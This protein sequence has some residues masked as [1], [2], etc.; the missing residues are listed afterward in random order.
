M[1]RTLTLAM[2]V[3]LGSLL[4]VDGIAVSGEM[5]AVWDQDPNKQPNLEELK[6]QLEDPNFGTRCRAVGRL[7]SMRAHAEEVAPL[8]IRCFKDPHHDVRSTA[9]N[10]FGNLQNALPDL[11]TRFPESIP[12]LIQMLSDRDPEDRYQKVRRHAA[13]A[14]GHLGEPSKAAAPELLKIAANRKDNVSVRAKAVQALGRIGHASPEVIKTLLG[15]L[16]D[17]ARYNEFYPTISST[18]H[19]ALERLGTE[20]KAALPVLIERLKRSDPKHRMVAARALGT[21]GFDSLEAED[22]LLDLLDDEDADVQKAALGSVEGVNT[23]YAFFFRN[24]VSSRE[25]SKKQQALYDEI[26]RDPDRKARFV[27]LLAAQ[28]RLGRGSSRKQVSA[29]GKLVEL[30]ASDCLPLFR[31]RFDAMEKKSP[32]LERGDLRL[33]LLKAIAQLLPAKERIPFLIG[34]ESDEAEAMKVRF[35]ATVLLCASGDKKA[36]QHVLAGYKAAQQKYKRTTHMT[37]D[38]QPQ[39]QKSYQQE[40]RAWDQDVDMIADYTEE[41]LLLDPAND[42]TDGDGVLDGNDRNPLCAPGQTSPENEGITQFLLYLHTKYRYPSR[43]PFSFKVWIVGTT[44]NYDGKGTPS[45][46]RGVEFTGVEG[47][48]LHLSK[49]QINEYRSLH[50]YGTPIFNLHVVKGGG[51]SEKELNFSEYVAPLGAAG[52]KIRMKRFDGVWLPVEWTMTWIS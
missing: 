28:L 31:K 20:A 23:T 39:Y 6:R 27:R 12:Q 47:V 32:Y 25:V 45:I 15:L 2:V 19:S 43:G 7:G 16:D 5:V 3:G 4:L 36:I 29:V 30:D 40:K 9:A 10:T 18:A 34:V 11:G 49:E 24:N 35:R 52:W 51:D 48:V 14:L 22:A 50:G 13:Y 46:F 42:D 33:Q 1:R 38:K 21:V 44:D 37:I 26:R 17:P 8:I 41:G